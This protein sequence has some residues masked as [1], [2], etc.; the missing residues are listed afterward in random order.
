M[1]A[2]AQSPPR[3]PAAEG[4]RRSPRSPRRLST[5]AP[6][7]TVRLR[8]RGAPAPRGVTSLEGQPGRLGHLPQVAGRSVNR[9]EIV[10]RGDIGHQ[11]FGTAGGFNQIDRV[12]DDPLLPTGLVHGRK[13]SPGDAASFLALEPDS[14]SPPDVAPVANLEPQVHAVLREAKASR[15]GVHV[16]HDDRTAAIPRNLDNLAPLLPGSPE[17]E[18]DEHADAKSQTD[19]QAAGRGGPRC[20]QPGRRGE[21]HPAPPPPKLVPVAPRGELRPQRFPDAHQREA[22]RVTGQGRCCR[23]KRGGA[24]PGRSARSPRRPP[25]ALPAA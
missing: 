8:G 23:W 11:S 3:P 14:F 9:L 24:C 17:Q 12:H 10:R 21:R 16:P 25:S 18:H 22:L 20:S 5:L 4:R 15:A 19:R 13:D 2:S 1:Y 7:A 6:A